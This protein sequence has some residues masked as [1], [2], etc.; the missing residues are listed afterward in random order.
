MKVLM[1]NGSPHPAG[2]TFTALSEVASTL[3]AE[4]IES[5]IVNIGV[6]PLNGCVACMK[7]RELKKCAFNDGVNDFL[8]KADSADAFIFGAPVHYASAA[9]AVIAFMD[10]LFYAAGNGGRPSFYLKPAA[11]V[12]AARRG[13]T[14]AAF[15]Q[16][17]KYF[18][19]SSMPV[20]SS[21]YWNMVHGA[22]PEDAKQDLEGMQTMRTLARNMAWFL[23][24]KEAGA[25]A[26]VPLPAL[27]ARVRT[28]FI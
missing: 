9:G 7:C 8:D 2:T 6:K 22:S 19:V 4:G 14:T 23:K 10:R 13:G 3:A 5:E 16:L 24:C 11:A 26:G 21:Q 17:N 25:K 18:T 20:I 27:E 12:V 15:D 28:N 1:L